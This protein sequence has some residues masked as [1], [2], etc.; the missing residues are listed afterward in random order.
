VTKSN[1]ALRLVTG[2][3]CAF[4][5]AGAAL[6]ADVPVKAPLLPPSAYNWTGIYV[7]AHVGYGGGMKDWI[8]FEF[9]YAAK[10][11]LG[12]IQLGINQ[13]I[14]NWLIGIEGD[15][16][17]ADI[18]GSQGY[19][20]FGPVDGLRITSA[21]SS[22]IDMVTTVAGRLGF[23]AD[24]W[25]VYIKA[26]AAWAH[27]KHTFN[28]T[29]ELFGRSASVGTT[30]VNG[31]ETRF[32][33][34]FGV[35]AEYA[36]V[37]S[38]SAKLEYNY[39]DFRTGSVN[40]IGSRAASG[41]V[42]PFVT[43]TGLPQAI[44]LVKL[45]VNYRFGPD[46]PPPIAPSRPAPGFDWSGAYIGAQGSYGFGRTNWAVLPPDRPF[47][48]KGWFAGA[49][50][51]AN[52]QA[53]AF[54]AGVEAEWMWG[55]VNGAQSFVTPIIG[56]PGTQTS[57]ETSNI[58]WLAMATV[59]LGFIAADR[60]LVYGKGGLAVAH[61]NHKFDALRLVTGLGTVV[62]NLT[63]EAL[64]TG[65]VAGAGVEYAFLGNWSAKL[66]YDYVAF[67]EQTFLI[68]GPETLN[69]TGRVGTIG[70]AQPIR[71]RQDLH[72]VKFGLNYHFSPLDVVTARY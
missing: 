9:D 66:E 61:E 50:V 18:K 59:R 33:P 23:A 40:L 12:G 68:S 39:L 17:W 36:F 3:L 34:M 19:V 31:A 32:G 52:A 27:E 29:Q 71:I 26:G 49:T 15:F 38:W 4:G 47:D 69:V 45:G 20:R 11:P 51:G 46:A 41:F 70:T 1:T 14:G 7:G 8:N 63:A 24:R 54:V 53:G 60:W 72:L 5:P 42:D 43:T 16:S 55:R 62:D 6:A 48:S 67:R 25:L 13:Q 21:A 56:A 2:A 35:G 30:A 57:A 58:D 64:R 65:A 28:E 37:A 22:K 44:H 10:G